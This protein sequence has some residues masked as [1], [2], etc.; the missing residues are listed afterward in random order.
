LIISHPIVIEHRI[1]YEDDREAANVQK[2]Q[3]KVINDALSAAHYT[4]VRASIL[5][6][7]ETWKHE[8]KSYLLG[9]YNH[10]KSI[11]TRPLRAAPK[12][13]AVLIHLLENLINSTIPPPPTLFQN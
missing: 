7:D 1:A 11:H 8:S 9:A 12:E 6:G 2:S 5:R 3:R 4:N 13:K 10:L